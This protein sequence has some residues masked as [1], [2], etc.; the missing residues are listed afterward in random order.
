[1]SSRN[2]S[3]ISYT[4]KAFGQIM[5]K[6]ADI[7]I[8]EAEN[9]VPVGSINPNNVDLPGIFVNR[10][11]PATDQKSIEIKKLRSAE[12]GSAVKLE[13]NVA[14][15]QRN[16]IAKRAAKELKQGYYVNLGVGKKTCIFSLHCCSLTLYRYPHTSS[17]IFTGECQGLGSV[18]EWS[19]GNG[20]SVGVWLYPCSIAKR[21]ARDRTLWRMKWMRKLLFHSCNCI[22][23]LTNFF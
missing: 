22:F 9:I 2:L 7:T 10:I 16:R 13:K 21:M 23:L 12:N 11:V 20:K 18:R 6:A 4:T 19:S 5:A 15:T 8:V 14:L 1:M 17:I 3:M